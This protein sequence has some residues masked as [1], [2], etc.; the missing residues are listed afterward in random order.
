LNQVIGTAG[1]DNVV[2]VRGRIPEDKI[3]PAGLVV[4]RATFAPERLLELVEN[5]LLPDGILAV[6]A[7]KKP[8]W[9]LKGG[10]LLT[11]EF[12]FEISGASRWIGCLKKS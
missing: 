7:A 6:M 2:W 11:Q 10:W 9:D 8:D 4:S 5:L 1:L 12:S 3:Q